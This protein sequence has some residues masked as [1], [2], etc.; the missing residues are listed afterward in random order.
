MSTINLRQPQATRTSG[1]QYDRVSKHRKIN[2]ETMIETNPAG[3]DR[4]A[5]K[6]FFTLA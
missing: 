4:F 2:I 6:V 1:W 5:G 3:Q